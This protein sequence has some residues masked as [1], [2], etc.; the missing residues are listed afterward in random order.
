MSH[1]RCQQSSLDDTSTWLTSFA[2]KVLARAERSSKSVFVDSQFL[3]IK[4]LEWLKNAQEE[5]GC[6]E[7]VGFVP[8]NDSFVDPVNR[9]LAMN[10]VVL[11]NI[12][13][14]TRCGKEFVDSTDSIESISSQI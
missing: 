7:M 3:F 10:S 13:D 5:D 11:G 2:V 4:P 9:K 6:F 12:I 14:A 1:P 8:R